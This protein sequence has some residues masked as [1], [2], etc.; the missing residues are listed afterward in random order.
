MCEERRPLE[1]VAQT[2]SSSDCLFSFPH[3]WAFGRAIWNS[4]AVC[5]VH[6]LLVHRLRIVSN[7]M[8]LGRLRHITQVIT[9]FI[10]NIG[11]I[12]TL[13]TGFICPYFYCYGCPL[14]STAC[15]IGTL[16]HFV[17]FL[18]VPLYLLGTLGAYGTVFGRAFCG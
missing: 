9:F 1:S 10:S 2:N 14:A 15:P 13:K 16:Q 7:I 5:E 3:F 6:L 17:I 8:N 4:V 12:P 11:L 18:T